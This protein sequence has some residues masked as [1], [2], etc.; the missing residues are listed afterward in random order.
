MA[1]LSTTTT[2]LTVTFSKTA[3]DKAFETAE[4]A[5][6]GSTSPEWLALVA[7]RPNWGI[8]LA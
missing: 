8:G 1:A 7:T 5:N 2:G 4:G 3:V 6:D